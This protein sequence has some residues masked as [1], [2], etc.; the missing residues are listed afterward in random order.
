MLYCRSLSTGYEPGF[1]L[2]LVVA[3]DVLVDCPLKSISL[4]W[5]SRTVGNCRSL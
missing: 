5:D 2:G 3:L 4:S 1:C